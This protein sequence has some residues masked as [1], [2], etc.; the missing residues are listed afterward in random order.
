MP[1]WTSVYP[2][3]LDTFTGSPQVDAADIVWAN[4][5]NIPAASIQAIE[6]KLGVTGGNAT[7]FGGYSF[8]N[9]GKA[10]FPGGAGNPTL[11]VDNSWGPGF[12]LTYTDELGTDWP[13]NALSGVGV[14][15]T[16]ADPAI[17]AG[18]LVGVNP[19]GAVDDVVRA[20]ANA[21]TVYTMHGVVI[22]IYGAGTL[23]DIMYSGEIQ[24]AA[25]AGVFTQGTPVFLGT[26]GVN[27]GLAASPPGGVG[28]I[29]QEVGFFRNA[30]TLVIRPSLVTTI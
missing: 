16:V 29:Q 6:A 28:S 19:A 7:G 18:D 21:G 9:T 2:T 15:Y 13:I 5:V 22:G 23:C 4:N 10:A 30:D 25:W 1:L 11:W 14:G 8:Q 24:N 27:S 12:I 3:S 26:K 20:D 17:V